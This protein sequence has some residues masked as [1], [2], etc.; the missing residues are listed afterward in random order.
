MKKRLCSILCLCLCVCLLPSARA[1]GEMKFPESAETF[2]KQL[3][4]WALTLCTGHAA[5]K[6]ARLF[7]QNGLKVLMQAN[8]DKQDDD[9]ANTCAYTVG[10]GAAI[11]GG[12]TRPLLVIAIRGT[13]A[14]E[15]YSNFDFAP[16]RSRDAAFAENFLFCA[17][18][19]FLGIKDIL[20]AETKPIVLV[21]GHS[22]GAACAN[23]LGVLLAGLMAQDDLYVYTFA[24]PA[25][26]RGKKTTQRNPNIFNLINPEDIVPMMPLKAWGYARAGIDIY[27]DGDAQTVAETEKAF[28]VLSDLAPSIS[29]YYGARH[30]LTRA[31]QS[32]DGVTAFEAMLL[33]APGLAGMSESGDADISDGALSQISAESDLRP[34]AELLEKLS[35]DDGAGFKEVL[36]RHMP[37]TYARL[38]NAYGQ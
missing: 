27:L 21:C 22:R 34:L 33:L 3:A 20:E 31:G 7:T 26:I 35:K 12:E 14:S 5:D 37:D 19:V 32:E 10:R 11:R 4:G 38:L 30:S 24:T 8:Y 36:A 16:S 6:T 9:K 25:T 18:D 17:Q 13:N 29:E 28:G 23:L 15:W 1:A 2:S